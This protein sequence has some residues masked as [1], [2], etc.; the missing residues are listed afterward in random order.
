VLP[1]AT[2]AAARGPLVIVTQRIL[3]VVGA[4]GAAF[5]VGTPYAVLA[6]PKF[7][8]DYARLAYGFAQVRGGEPG[9]SLYVKYVQQSL[10]WPGLAVA[11]AGAAI[12]IRSMVRG[13]GRLQSLL[14]IGFPL[15]Y[16]KVMA[17]SF[18]I[19]GRYTL[20]L[21]PFA[22]LL[23]AIGTAA[24]V[25]ALRTRLPFQARAGITAG[26]LIAI[27]APPLVRSIGFDRM[28]GSPGT[29][30]LAY[31]YIESH[32]PPGAVIVSETY[33]TLLTTRR[34]KVRNVR[35]LTGRSYADYMAGGVNYAL[36]SSA[37][38]HQAYSA[39]EQN[40]QAYDAYISLFAQARELAAFP[41][42]DAVPGPDLRLLLLQPLAPAPPT[43]APS[44]S[45]PAA[46]VTP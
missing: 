13:P 1:L 36:L 5:L 23:A 16:F 8:A 3:A 38:Y 11:I 2:V 26:L 28:L 19:Y 39:P 18:Q 7:L 35:P 29:T 12:A 45:A 4:A 33:P 22:A 6:L 24:V 34:Y 9:W 37:G 10:G 15:L 40:R 44:P 25:R 43:A 41:G 46:A 21:L 42:S 32:I 14:L 17:T 30:D 31:H 27:V 20:P